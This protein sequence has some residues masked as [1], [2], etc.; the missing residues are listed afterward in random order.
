MTSV[1]LVA[2]RI[3]YDA[4]FQPDGYHL[5]PRLDTGGFLTDYHW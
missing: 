3:K 2:T 4:G 5:L 1:I